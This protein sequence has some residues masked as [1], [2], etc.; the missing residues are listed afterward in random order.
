MVFKSIISEALNVA[1]YIVSYCAQKK[2]PVSNLKLQK[3]L[4]FIWIDYYK[5]TGKYLF[6]DRFYAWQL[7]PVVPIVYFEYC[8]YGGMPIIPFHSLQKESYPISS[9][10]ADALPRLIDPYLHKS[11][12]DLVNMTHVDGTAWS[13]VFNN[14]QG[15]KK[16]IPFDYICRDAMRG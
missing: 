4:Y 10:L 15:N 9:E 6:E 14:G 16:E 3:M 13:R 2:K 12:R 8:S 1:S 11:A 5:S 7:G